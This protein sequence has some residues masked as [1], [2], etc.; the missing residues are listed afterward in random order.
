MHQAVR[1]AKRRIVGAVLRANVP[2]GSLRVAAHCHDQG[3]DRHQPDFDGRL[4]GTLDRID[5][6][7]RRF[8]VVELQLTGRQR[9]ISKHRLGFGQ[10]QLAQA[11]QSVTRYVPCLLYT[12]DAADDRT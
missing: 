5:R 10:R 3:F 7:S 1:C 8:E 11:P 6:A 12:S 4:G 2:Q 9:L